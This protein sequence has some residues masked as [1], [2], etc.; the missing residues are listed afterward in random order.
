MRAFAF[1]IENQICRVASPQRSLL[2][3][4]QPR[5]L[6]TE[7]NQEHESEEEGRDVGQS[8]RILDLT[9]RFFF[10]GEVSSSS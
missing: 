1:R 3:P 4:L 9:F 2:F 6:L 7:C 5:K 8:H 10:T